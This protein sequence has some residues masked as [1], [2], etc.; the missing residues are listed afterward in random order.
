MSANK[1]VNAEKRTRLATIDEAATYL[2]VSRSLLY[3]L[4]EDGTLKYVKIGKCRRLLW[5]SLDALVVESTV[6]R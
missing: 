6:E 2:S 3:S 4:M 5:E 1:P